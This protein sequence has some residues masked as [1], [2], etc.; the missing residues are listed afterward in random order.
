M[1]V[2]RWKNRHATRNELTFQERFIFERALYRY[3][4]LAV[5]T[6]RIDWTIRGEA[7]AEKY[8]ELRTYLVGFTLEEICQLRD[9]HAF[10]YRLARW[11]TGGM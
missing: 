7:R 5:H 9:V 4:T 6:E 10:I 2:C 3:W 8:D 1:V 11:H